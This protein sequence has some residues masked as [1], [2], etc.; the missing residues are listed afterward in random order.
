VG[1]CNSETDPIPDWVT[2]LFTQGSRKNKVSFSRAAI[3]VPDQGVFRRAVLKTVVF[4]NN[5]DNWVPDIGISI[6]IVYIKK[7]T[8]GVL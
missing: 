5:Q 2:M 8:L 3:F 1:Q 6:A 4:N 7:S